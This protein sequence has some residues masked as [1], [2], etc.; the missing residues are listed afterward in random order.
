VSDTT[1]RSRHAAK[2]TADAAQQM[3]AR[4]LPLAVR[5]MASVSNVHL[6]VGDHDVE[7]ASESDSDEDVSLYARGRAP[8]DH[9][10]AAQPS[11][12]EVVPEASS[13]AAENQSVSMEEL[14]KRLGSGISAE[15]SGTPLTLL[16]HAI[17]PIVCADG[18]P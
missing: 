6:P 12:F 9:T 17:V 4:A 16:S 13:T 1:G 8:T 14:T 3:R 7:I 15:P 18:V 5:W 10:A 11:L 2:D